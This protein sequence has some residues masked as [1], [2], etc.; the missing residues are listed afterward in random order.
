MI[1]QIM[2][3]I[4]TLEISVCLV[5]FRL[6]MRISF[7]LDGELLSPTALLADISTS[8]QAAENA[9]QYVGLQEIQRER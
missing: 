1:E 7:A 4:N 8:L 9:D 5:L 6:R 2:S 3:E